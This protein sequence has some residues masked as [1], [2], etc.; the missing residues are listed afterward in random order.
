MT[1][2]TAVQL[3][4]CPR[5]DQDDGNTLYILFSDGE[6]R[7]IQY[8][9]IEWRWSTTGP[10]SCCDE[11]RCARRDDDEE[12]ETAVTEQLERRWHRGDA[13]R[14]IARRSSTLRRLM[15]RR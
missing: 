3:V 5:R 6:V 9:G 13:R 12:A 11:Q 2:K 7:Q 14:P 4:V 1:R 10:A 15:G 8:D